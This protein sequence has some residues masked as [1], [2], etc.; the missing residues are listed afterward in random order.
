MSVR[1]FSGSIANGSP[2]CAAR[3]VRRL[4]R[5]FPGLM[6]AL[7]ATLMMPMTWAQ[8]AA[9]EAS[10]AHSLWIS[11]GTKYQVDPLC[12]YAIALQESRRSFSDGRVRPWP[13]TLH[14]QREGSLYFSTYQAALR[15]VRELLAAGTTNI[16]IGIS[17]ISWR[18]QGYRAGDV[19]VLLQVHRN[20]EISA[21]ILRE[22]LDENG[23]DLRL[24]IARYHN[25]RPEV[26]LPYAASVLAILDELRKVEGIRDALAGQDMFIAQE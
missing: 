8:E 9:R 12:L 6:L 24:A 22:N 19:A 1:S 16:D 20:I 18:Y 2:T 7:F 17:Q 13:W 25:P 14:T 11:V 3:A 5:A 23:G 15:K 26:G 21:Q 4:L 10:F